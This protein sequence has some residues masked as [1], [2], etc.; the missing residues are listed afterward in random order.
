VEDGVKCEKVES[1]NAKIDTYRISIPAPGP[2]PATA[3]MLLPKDA[4]PD[5]KKALHLSFHGY[6]WGNHWPPNPDWHGGGE[7]HIEVNAH[8]FELGRDAGYYKDFE[9]NATAKGMCGFVAEENK[10]P[11]TTYFNGM[12][13]RDL[14]VIEYAKSLPGWDGKNLKLSG[15]SQGGFQA[16]VL[17]GLERDVTFVEPSVPWICDMGG[18][19]RL[20]RYGAWQPDFTDA[21]NYYDPVHHAARIPLSCK[22]YISRNG[23]GDTVCP[24]SGIMAVYNN[25]RGPKTMR[26]VQGSEHG[27]WGGMPEG[28]QEL[29][30]EN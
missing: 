24:P 23:M 3:F 17:A 15:G 26:M 1:G 12:I 19:A 27:D 5:T 6:G 20:G 18:K 30:I 10:S 7:I 13:L 4:G 2:Q 29:R 25:I 22:V 14:R 21:L 16:L 8:D 9:R 28:T 11:E